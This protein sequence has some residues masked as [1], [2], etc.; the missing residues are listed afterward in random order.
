MANDIDT[1]GGLVCGLIIGLFLGGLLYDVVDFDTTA[2]RK[3]AIE[4]N[5]AEYRVD[6]KTGETAFVW[7]PCKHR[8]EVGEPAESES[9]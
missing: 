2:V 9:E 1:I 6:P 3:E 7:L 8:Q 5:C 4:N